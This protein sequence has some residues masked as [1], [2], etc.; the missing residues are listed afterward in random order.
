[1][2][3]LTLIGK[4]DGWGKSRGAGRTGREP[5]TTVSSSWTTDHGPN[6]LNIV[7]IDVMRFGLY[8]VFIWFFTHHQNNDILSTI[9]VMLER[10]GQITYTGQGVRGLQ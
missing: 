10:R 7:Q 6:C 9:D 1:M 5:W 4:D 8:I 3:L 2:L